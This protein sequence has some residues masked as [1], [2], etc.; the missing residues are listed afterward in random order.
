[1]RLLKQIRP[2]D[3]S[4]VRSA[5]ASVRASSLRSCTCTTAAASASSSSSLLIGSGHT[6]RLAG[7]GAGMLA[8]GSSILPAFTFGGAIQVRNSTKRGGGSTKNNRNSP[9]KRLGV[10]RYGGALRDRLP[11]PCVRCD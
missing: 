10:K 8:A 1:M 3:M 2:F 4:F 6:L 9:G 11:C 7:A 5:C